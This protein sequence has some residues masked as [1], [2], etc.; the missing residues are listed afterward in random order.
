MKGGREGGREKLRN[1]GKNWK[2]NY[3]QKKTEKCSG[4][5]ELQVMRNPGNKKPTQ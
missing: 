5:R 3:A 2:I 1:D 4:Q